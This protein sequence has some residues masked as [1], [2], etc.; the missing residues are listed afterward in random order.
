VKGLSTHSCILGSFGAAVWQH[1]LWEELYMEN[2]LTPELELLAAFVDQQPP[3]M[4][5]AFQFCAAVVM[6]GRRGEADQ[7]SSG[8]WAGVV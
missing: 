2:E 1:D 6:G 4:R 5:Q 3:E 8:G 7:H